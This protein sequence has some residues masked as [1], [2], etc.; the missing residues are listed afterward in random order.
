M[1]GLHCT[2][3]RS[4]LV[5]AQLRTRAHDTDA[6]AVTHRQSA[7]AHELEVSVGDVTH[8][9]AVLLK[10]LRLT[11]TENAELSEKCEALKRELRGNGMD[12]RESGRKDQGDEEAGG[13]G[14]S[15]MGSRSNSITGAQMPRLPSLNLG[16]ERAGSENGRGGSGGGGGI[17]GFCDVP[18][19]D[20][21]PN[22]E[23]MGKGGESETETAGGDEV[24]E[25][26]TGAEAME[27]VEP[28]AEGGGQQGGAGAG[29]REDDGCGRGEGAL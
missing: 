27:V 13:S 11:L 20:R 21:N 12:G 5:P 10:E 7:L 19:L 24:Q 2:Y 9:K 26:G 17:G 4:M 22:Q 25:T 1:R 15:S 18:G 6:L 28:A 23:P 16:E 29:A 14:S 8:D 3:V